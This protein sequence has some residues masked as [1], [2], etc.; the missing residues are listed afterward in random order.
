MQKTKVL[1]ALGVHPCPG[2]RRGKSDRFIRR[3]VN[4]FL[5]KHVLEEGRNATVIHEATYALFDP[6]MPLHCELPEIRH[7]STIPLDDLLAAIDRVATR[8]MREKTTEIQARTS[9]LNALYDSTVNAGIRPEKPLGWEAMEQP[10]QE[11]N[12]RRAGA[13]KMVS[14]PGSF[15]ISLAMFKCEVIKQFLYYHPNLT[16]D[17]VLRIAKLLVESSDLV[18][19]DLSVISF[20][21]QIHQ[22]DPE[23]VIIIPRGVGHVSMVTFFDLNRSDITVK[24]HGTDGSDFIRDLAYYYHTDP[25]PTTLADCAKLFADSFNVPTGVAPIKRILIRA[26]IF[27]KM[28]YLAMEMV[29]RLEKEY[30]LSQN[31]EI[32]QKL[33]Y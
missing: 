9:K 10:V 26:L 27:I 15:E 7:I 2:E 5:A 8:V 12:L 21:D 25:S 19:R 11:M 6:Y 24:Q 23:S 16:A 3:V 18:H 4:G 33:G 31:P 32:A 22:K 28:N 29:L 1:L 14:E 17:E 20:A 13:V 30:A